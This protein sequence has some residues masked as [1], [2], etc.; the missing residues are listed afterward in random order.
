MTK[1]HSDKLKYD[2]KSILEI[3]SGNRTPEPNKFREL[4]ERL[5]SYRVLAKVFLLDGTPFVFENSPMKYIIFK[6]QVAD[7]FEIGSQDVCIVGSAR[8]GFS[9]SPYKY[10]KSF[11]EASDVDV[12]VISEGLFD[13][14]SQRLFRYLNNLPP[15]THEIREFH[16]TEKGGG[17]KSTPQVP[18]ANW[19][20]TKE[21]IRNFVYQNFNP[22]LLPHDDDLRQEIFEKISSTAGLFLALEP[23]VFV[24]KIRCRVFRTWRSAEDYYSNSLRELAR[25]FREGRVG[26]QGVVEDDEE[27]P[28]PVASSNAAQQSIA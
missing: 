12:V 5:D 17:A 1:A 6:E 21:A 11:T 20:S 16:G 27:E 2:D 25:A 23:K 22:A 18:L 3:F 10:G 8:L 14:G 9:P 13:T 28:A 19:K 15:A 26:A 4:V 7:R 24:S